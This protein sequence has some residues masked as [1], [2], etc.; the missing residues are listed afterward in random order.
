MRNLLV[1]ILL[2]I[3][4]WFIYR[5]VVH[6]DPQ[7]VRVYKS[8]VES[9]TKGDM[10]AIRP[11]C[12]DPRVEMVFSVRSLVNLCQPMGISNVVEFKHEGV[13]SSPGQSS[14]DYI[15]KGQVLVF[16]NPHGVQAAYAATFRGVFEVRMELRNVAK[17]WTVTSVDIQGKEIG[18]HKYKG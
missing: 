3:V 5:N 15:V 12:A 1:L 2:A 6:Q 4:G 17:Q 16:F 9:W 7:E 14:T 18:E 8:M 10:N 11:M 13:T